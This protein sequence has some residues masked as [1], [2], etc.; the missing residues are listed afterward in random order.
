MEFFYW[1]FLPQKLQKQTP[2][3]MVFNFEY[4]ASEMKSIEYDDCYLFSGKYVTY[5]K[6]SR[7]SEILNA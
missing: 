7:R 1:V 6:L 5:S 2:N 4:T 3:C